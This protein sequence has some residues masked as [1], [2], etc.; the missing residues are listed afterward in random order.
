MFQL[1]GEAAY[2][3]EM[4]EKQRDLYTALGVEPPS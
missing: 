3:G 2:F 1:P 4:T